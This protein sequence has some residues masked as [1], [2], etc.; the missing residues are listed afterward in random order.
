M[1]ENI[2]LVCPSPTILWPPNLYLGVAWEKNPK[3]FYVGMGSYRMSQLIVDVQGYLIRDIISGKHELHDLSNRD[4]SDIEREEVMKNKQSGNQIL[5]SSINYVKQLT[6]MT[7]YPSYDIEKLVSMYNLSLKDREENF[8]TYRD[9]RTF[10]SIHTGQES[11][12]GNKKWLE[13]MD[14]EPKNPKSK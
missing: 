6:K 8:I 7:G 4:P 12:L 9:V 5:Y 10:T 3:L 2:R 1:E 11:C 14:V 13:M